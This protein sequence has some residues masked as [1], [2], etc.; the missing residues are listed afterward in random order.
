M[1][2]PAEHYERKVNSNAMLLQIKKLIF[3]YWINDSLH[4]ANF[5][6]HLIV[7]YS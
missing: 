2:L 1:L 7:I 5:A 3:P 4:I 6:L